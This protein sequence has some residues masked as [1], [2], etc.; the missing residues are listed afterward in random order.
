MLRAGEI[1]QEDELRD[2]SPEG[3]VL[4][5]AGEAMVQSRPAGRRDLLEIPPSE[6]LAVLRRSP[7]GSMHS[8][9]EDEVLLRTLLGHYGFNR[10]TKTRREYL[11]KV[12]R[13]LRL[14]DQE[15]RTTES[16]RREQPET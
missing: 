14:P 2:A 6:L 15:G 8:V 5:L 12:L 13:V 3:Q 1:L 10:L 4:R 7:R 9:D 16:S 11:S